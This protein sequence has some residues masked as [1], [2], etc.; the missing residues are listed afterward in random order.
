[1]L[2]IRLSRQMKHHVMHVNLNQYTW[3]HTIYTKMFYRVRCIISLVGLD[4][5]LNATLLDMSACARTD[6]DPTVVVTTVENLEKLLKALNG[7]GLVMEEKVVESLLVTVDDILSN[8]V[9]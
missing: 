6:T 3:Y 5:L 4:K 1:M 7:R 9:S 8:K 2:V